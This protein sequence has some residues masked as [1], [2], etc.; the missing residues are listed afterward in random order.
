M[1]KLSAKNGGGSWPLDQQNITIGRRPDNPIVVTDSFASGRHAM[2]G[3]DG[4]HYFVEDLKSS[5]GTLLNGQRITRATL[6]FGDVIKIGTQDL[7][8]EDDMPEFGT[9]VLSGPLLAQPEAARAAPITA[10]PP[11][12]PMSP[13]TPTA[14]KPAPIASPV[15][16][17]TA[18]EIPELSV[19]LPAPRPTPPPPP[20]AI[21]FPDLLKAAE[22]LA[23]PRPIAAEAQ[24]TSMLD[25]LVGSIRSHRD[26]EQQEREEANVR[27]RGEWDKML[28]LAEELKAK[29]GQDPRV[30]RFIVDRRAQ[31][32]MIQLQRTAGTPPLF[33]T[34]SLH[35]P[36]QKS[37]TLKGIWLRRTGEPDRCLP[38]AQQVGT[39]LIRDLA[40]LLA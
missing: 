31:D 15:S 22:T 20:P 10:T 4:Q 12:P 34:V 27:V 19:D 32:V 2:V 3:W 18:P 17:A 25:E 1:A 35:H 36:D 21:E 11:S 24:P 13:P 29:T 38:T 40:F 23:P 9:L 8:F 14:T 7:L 16:P 39:E 28:A 26:R 6:K 30:K 37:E 33:I 5:N